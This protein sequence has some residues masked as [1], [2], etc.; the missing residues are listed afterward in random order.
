MADAIRRRAADELGVVVEAITEALPHF[1]Y[2]AID[3]SGI[4]ENEVCPVFLART[5]SDPSPAADEVCEWKWVSPDNLTDSIRHTPFV[6]SPW[7]VEQ[8][9]QWQGRYEF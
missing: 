1:R 5:S 6:F 7:L 8:I 4:V 3:A 9:E 2:R